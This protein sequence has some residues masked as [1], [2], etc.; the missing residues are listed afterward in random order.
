[1]RQLQLFGDTEARELFYLK[2]TLTIMAIR[3]K[4]RIFEAIRVL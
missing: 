1:M 4:T 2:P 3:M